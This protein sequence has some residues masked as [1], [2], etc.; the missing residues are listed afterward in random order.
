MLEIT[1]QSRLASNGADPT[2]VSYPVVAEHY[3]SDSLL[4]IRSEG[5]LTLTG[6]P[7]DPRPRAYGTSLGKALFD[8]DIRDA[9]K[10]AQSEASG[11]AQVLLEIEAEELRAWR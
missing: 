10:L 4:P 9:F 3:R 11:E 5:W 2:E 8:G 6:E 1:V 7:L